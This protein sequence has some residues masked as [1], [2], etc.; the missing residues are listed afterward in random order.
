MNQQQIIQG[1][2]AMLNGDADLNQH[3]IDV[4]CAAIRALG[5]NP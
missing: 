2:R 5:G 4:I 1:L 3:Q